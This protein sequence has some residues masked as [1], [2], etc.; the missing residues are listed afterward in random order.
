MEDSQDVREAALQF[1]RSLS[2][3]DSD[4]PFSEQ[5]TSVDAA[6]IL[7]GT[8]EKEWVQGAQACIAAFRD[9]ART[10]VRVE[11]GDI[12]AYAEE[13]IGWIVDRPTVILLDGRR[14]PTRLTAV[15]R[16]ED[17]RWRHVTSHMSIGIAD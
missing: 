17:G 2:S 10:G 12:R 5:V 1:Y 9:Q 14:I 6:A 3:P 16:L 11:P 7:I 4:I 8:D 15:L 13:S